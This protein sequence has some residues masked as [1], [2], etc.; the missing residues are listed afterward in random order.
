VH[1]QAKLILLCVV[2]AAI[3]YVLI[4]PLPELA[5]TSTLK[6]PIFSLILV[7][8]LLI[9]FGLEIPLFRWRQRVVCFSECHLLLAFTCVRLC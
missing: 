5:A 1:S 4:S 8:L 7:V 6:L 3:L 9:G 2:I